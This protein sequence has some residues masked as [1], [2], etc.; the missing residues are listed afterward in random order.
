M[1]SADSFC[2]SVGLAEMSEGTEA[3]TMQVVNAGLGDRKIRFNEEN[4]EKIV[5]LIEKLRNIQ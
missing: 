2:S 3:S 5:D 4:K 1:S